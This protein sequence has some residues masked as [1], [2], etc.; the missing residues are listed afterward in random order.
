MAESSGIAVELQGE[1]WRMES[2]SDVSHG[3]VDLNEISFSVTSLPCNTFKPT[4]A[5]L[6]SDMLSILHLL[7]CSSTVFLPKSAVQSKRE[8][9]FHACLDRMNRVAADWIFPVANEWRGKKRVTRR[10]EKDR[11]CGIKPSTR[12][13]DE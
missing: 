12:Y 3:H 4:F 13:W 8:Y 10:K 2:M 9:G 7:P 1:R 11:K 6:T 5:C